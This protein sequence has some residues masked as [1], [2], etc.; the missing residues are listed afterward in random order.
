[1][2]S[3]AHRDGLAHARAGR[4][5]QAIDA[6][7]R[8][9]RQEGEGAA[10]LFSLGEAAAALGLTPTATAM[11]ARCLFLEPGRIDATV[12]LSEM[13]AIADRE[14]E[15][16]D[17][18]REAAS[19]T[20]GEASLWL[21]LGNVMTRR[22]D[23]VNAVTFYEEALRLRPMDAA[24]LG[25][26]ADIRFDRG[27]T[28]AALNL[29]DKALN[30]AGK[31]PQLRLN[32][33]LALLSLGNVK[34]GWRD[35]EARLQI[36]SRKILRGHSLPRWTG[37]SLRG[38]RLL[39]MAEQGIG[40]QIMFASCLTGLPEESL[41]IECEARL[42]PIFARSFPKAQVYAAAIAEEAGTIKA[43][44]A[45]MKDLPSARVAIEIASLPMLVR[46]QRDDFPSPH[47][48]LRAEEEET[49]K[50]RAWLSAAGSR[51]KVGIC[52][53]SGKADGIRAKHY[54][55]LHHWAELIR[56]LDAEIINLQYALEEREAQGLAAEAGKPLLV[57]PALDQK[58]ELDRTL[59]LM[60]ALDLIITAPT[61]V[62]AMAAS[63]GK[64]VLKLCAQRPWSHLGGSVDPFAPSSEA[65]W[66]ERQGDWQSLFD[67]AH[68]RAAQILAH[69]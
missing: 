36:P 26:L 6:Y 39:V 2:K 45:G 28:Q 65:L 7:E 3:D 53:R 21:A 43:D 19:R 12:R 54:A 42:R 60:N 27:E 56:A 37:E 8:A 25:N 51:P 58:H 30:I 47:A 61:A 9:L 1:M 4:W 14:A 22:D 24:A 34:Q 18:L 20:P 32:R 23:T 64:P 55:A 59:G 10:L 62:A 52:W 35:Y 67:A 13:L 48:Y 29:Y 50:W 69:P 11:F 16:I 15:A 57:P 46:R 5:H 31:N 68:S 17:L 41:I 49:A 44:Y 40:D 38:R 33:A 63:I 66:P